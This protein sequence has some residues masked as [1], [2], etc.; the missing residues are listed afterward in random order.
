MS[1]QV[2]GQAD[3]TKRRNFLSMGKIFLLTAAPSVNHQ[4]AGQPST[5][6]EDGAGKL[7]ASGC[8]P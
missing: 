3:A 1:A 4:K 5:W 7:P 8:N 6:T 2:K